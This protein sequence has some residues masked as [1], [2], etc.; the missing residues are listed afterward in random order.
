[1]LVHVE[2]NLNNGGLFVF[3]RDRWKFQKLHVTPYPTTLVRGIRILKGEKSC[4][5]RDRFSNFSVIVC[6]ESPFQR[7]TIG[8]AI[9]IKT[10]NQLMLQ[11]PLLFRD[12]ANRARRCDF[13]VPN[14]LT[15]FLCIG[16]SLWL[17]L[18]WHI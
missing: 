13:S 16:V 12:E 17:P 5:R 15:R 18:L 10:T 3:S 7:S 14:S 8:G 1:M 2:H 9:Q 4:A 11:Y 6:S